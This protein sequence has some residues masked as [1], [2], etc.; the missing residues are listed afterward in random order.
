MLPREIAEKEITSIH[1]V[2]AHVRAIYRKLGVTR[3]ESA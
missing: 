2:R 3:T 1:T